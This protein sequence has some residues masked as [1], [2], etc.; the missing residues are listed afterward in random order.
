MADNVTL[1]P[2]IVIF[3]GSRHGGQAAPNS[4]RRIAVYT[5]RRSRSDDESA[6]RAAARTSAWYVAWDKSC[7]TRPFV[8]SDR[9]VVECW[10][11]CCSASVESPGC[12]WA[13]RESLGIATTSGAAC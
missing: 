4:G 3:A 7:R 5:N 2:G 9:S 1:S 8:V 6:G 11:Y 10:E 12:C 13:V